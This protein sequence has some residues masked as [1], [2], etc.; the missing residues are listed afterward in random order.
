MSW[1]WTEHFVGSYFIY[2]I[3]DDGSISHRLLSLGLLFYTQITYLS[4]HGQTN[5][6]HQTN[7]NPFAWPKHSIYWETINK[8]DCTHPVQQRVGHN[9]YRNN[10]KFMEHYEFLCPFFSSLLTFQ[11]EWNHTTCKRIF[12]KFGSITY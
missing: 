9:V 2:Q 4:C 1:T 10:C 11:V 8:C 3:Q 6:Q 5:S 12:V 7:L